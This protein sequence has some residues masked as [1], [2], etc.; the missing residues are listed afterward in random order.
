VVP[1]GYRVEA[2]ITG[3]TFP[4]AVSFGPGG[5]LYLAESGGVEG[6][7]VSVPRVLRI[8][9]DR[10]VN[11]IGRLDN[12]IMG[13]VYRNG[14]LLI[15]EDGPSPRILRVTAEGEI[16]V[17]VDDLPGGGDYG[18][19][20]LSLDTGGGLLFGLG[21]RTNSGVVGLDNVARGWVQSRPDWADT[22]AADVEL[23][24]LNY[25]TARPGGPG[26]ATTGGFKPFGRRGDPGEHLAGAK[27][28]GGAVYRLPLD[29]SELE[30]VAWGLRNPVG[31]GIG[32]DGRLLCTER[33]MEERGS[34]PVAGAPDHLWD[35]KPNS[36]CGWPDH[37]GGIPI[38]EARFR[39][40]GHPPLRPLLA[41]GP[42]VTAPPI[43]A[44][45]AR[46]G[47][48]RFTVS[49]SGRFGMVG[50]LLVALSGEWCAPAYPSDE[51]SPAGY[52]VVRVDIHTGQSV[53]FL[54]NRHTAPASSG[55]TGGLERPFDVQFDPTGEVLY[56]VDIGEVQLTREFGIEPYGGTGVLWRVTP[57]HAMLV[58]PDLS[59]GEPSGDEPEE[60]TAF[61]AEIEPDVD[62][63]PYV[64]GEPDVEDEPDVEGT[65]EPE[66]AT[67]SDGAGSGES[68][69]PPEDESGGAAE[70]AAGAEGEEQGAAE[71]AVEPVSVSAEPEADEL[72]A[73]AGPSAVEPPQAEPV[74][75][76]PVAPADAVVAASEPAAEEPPAEV[77]A[78]AASPS[79][80]PAAEP[81]SSEGDE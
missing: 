7:Q 60:A 2:L 21:T 72:E 75:E 12:P 80:E 36:Y 56:V 47:V 62:G 38:S 19:S 5:E 65:P 15:G 53:D 78:E 8:D 22:V 16:R 68:E 71:V 20:G 17:L 34:R 74:P 63:A 40:P 23:A 50:E 31:V 28:S 30:K 18:L 1:H 61:D 42:V 25:V 59:G 64:G 32:P 67:F 70:D 46:S 69:A 66:P 51:N 3:L 76:E 14:E 73:S 43:A 77:V 48:G 4:S 9:P 58:V 35:L 39:L 44:F 13:L 37:V 81:S 24:G 52:R 79:D 55:N 45:P 26:K 27:R 41:R 6:Q 49:T 54:A 29:G 33:G 10:A 57:A 11:E